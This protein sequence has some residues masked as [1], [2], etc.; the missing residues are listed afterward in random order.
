MIMFV[1]ITLYP[2]LNTLAISLNDGTDALR[3]GI[4]LLPRKFTW[5]NYITVLQKDNLIMGAYITVA[6]TVIGTALA[7]F[8]NA[9]LA[10]IVSRKRFM[11]KKQLS[12]FWVITMYVNGGMIP[13][14]LLFKTL[15]LTNSFWVYVIPGMFSAFNMLVI[16]TY[17]NGISDSL[18][19]SAQLDGAG[20]TTIFLKII[21]PLCKPVYATVAL[22]VA[23]GQ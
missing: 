7:L 4:Y 11:F 1:I 12:L 5:K 6:R 19:E 14:F 23:V 18:E 22:F 15:H 8:A 9:I 3:G 2:V 17:M 16:R 13:T 21:S 20:Y 10:L